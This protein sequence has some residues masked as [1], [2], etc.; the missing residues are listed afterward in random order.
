MSE[1]LDFENSRL[2]ALIESGNDLIAIIDVNGIYSYVAP[3]V[4]KVLNE[5]PSS[6]LGKSFIEYIHPDDLPRLTEA[7]A[8]ILNGQERVQISPFRFLKNNGE[9]C[10][11]ETFATNKIH[12][13][14]I[15]GIVVNSRDVTSKVKDEIEK[16]ALFEKLRLANERYRLVLEATDDVIWELD[17]PSN[18][19]RRGKAFIKILGVSNCGNNEIDKSWEDFIHPKDK[20]KV[21]KSLENALKKPN[22]KFWRSEYRFLKGDGSIAYIIDQAYIVRDY[23]KKAIRMVGVMHDNTKLKERE[24]SIL[25]QNNQL[26]EIAY[27]TSHEIRRP[28]ASILGLL[29]IL[30]KKAI[31]DRTNSEILNLLEIAATEL[32]EII[33]KI[34]GKA[35]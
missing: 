10:W 11:V 14:A 1:S 29:N 28:V 5:N 3:S 2:E 20:L 6:F 33:K 12:D 22:V 15:R 35:S 26:R 27:I 19:I 25:M 32:D 23:H 24:L 18:E 30:D 31:R 8:L 16:T 21:L 7:F 34:V 9:W 17:I 4:K 13:P